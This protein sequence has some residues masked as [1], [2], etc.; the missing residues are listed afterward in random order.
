MNN[1]G[2]HGAEMPESRFIREYWCLVKA[3]VPVLWI[4]SFDHPEDDITSSAK[5][6]RV[7]PALQSLHFILAGIATALSILL[8]LCLNSFPMP[9]CFRCQF[10][11][12]L[13][14]LGFLRNYS[15]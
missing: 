15:S 9:C 10:V 3:A 2:R 13:K 14:I 7:L 12:R 6:K 4:L 5:M 11:E 1:M 8:H